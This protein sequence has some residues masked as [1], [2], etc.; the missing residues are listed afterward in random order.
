MQVIEE[1]PSSFGRIIKSKHYDPS[2]L[3]SLK[4]WC[5]KVADDEYDVH[6][7]IFWF[8]N[9]ITDFPRCSNMSCT[10]TFEHKNVVDWKRGYRKNCCPQC[11]KESDERKELYVKACQ[12]K[13]G[14]S[15][16][17]QAEDV[18]KK[19]AQS[20][21]D[22]Y[23]VDNVAKAPEVQ[24]TIRQ[25]NLDR[26]GA[27]IYINSVEGMKEIEQKCLERYGVAHYS[28]TAEYLEKCK[29][30][31]RKNYGTDWP[32]QN[33]EFMRNMQKRYTYDGM[34]FDSKPELAFYIWLK[35][36]NIDFIY[37]PDVMFEYEYDDVKHTYEP[38]FIVKG[39]ITEIKGDHF[40]KEDGTMCNPYDHSQ[41][42]LYEAKHQCMLANNVKVIKSAEYETYVDYVEKTYGKDWL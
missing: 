17:S 8:L 14:V 31:N 39:C 18:K 29:A 19:K 35:D 42:A 36:H 3:A 22:K 41:D 24:A 9:N 25:T 32:H 12:D 7:K 27:T 34:N 15:N 5:P 23:G 38:D 40:F 26:Y 28:Q 2:I 6:T 37:Q 13:Y 10:N 4:H 30:T 1:H 33:R 21:M 16:A 11:A 20:A